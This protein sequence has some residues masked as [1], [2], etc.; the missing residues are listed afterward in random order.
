MSL[1]FLLS[2]KI[3]AE[4]LPLVS[5]RCP[6]RLPSIPLNVIDITTLSRHDL[7]LSS[8]WA[9]LTSGNHAYQ[10]QTQRVIFIWFFTFFDTTETQR[11]IFIWFF[12]FFQHYR[13]T[14][15]YFYLIFYFFQHYRNT[16]GY[17]YLIFYFFQ[18][19]RNTE[20]YFYLI[21]YFFQLYRNT[22]GYFLFFQRII[23]TGHFFN[24]WLEQTVLSFLVFFRFSSHHINKHIGLFFLLFL[25]YIC[26][27]TNIQIY[28]RTKC[29]MDKRVFSV[30]CTADC[31][32]DTVP[33]Y[34]ILPST[35]YNWWNQGCATSLCWQCTTN[36]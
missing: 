27:Y 6:L 23:N 11:V 9:S 25:C 36:K 17:F 22:E 15:G 29:N 14:E 4:V 20:G 5:V 35:T 21:F 34:M 1:L 3:N 30:L 16:E 19:Y 28:Y 8:L 2:S 31:G 32:D 24:A 10:G 7:R 12:Y 13:N 26:I 33:R 18:H